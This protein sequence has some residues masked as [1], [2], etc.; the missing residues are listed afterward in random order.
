MKEREDRVVIDVTLVRVKQTNYECDD[1]GSDRSSFWMRHAKRCS[2]GFVKVVENLLV[3]M[4]ENFGHWL[5]KILFPSLQNASA[6]FMYL[7]FILLTIRTYVHSAENTK[8]FITSV[9]VVY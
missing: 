7:E 5:F 3:W 2:N 9:S 8:L 4:S 6:K 1:S